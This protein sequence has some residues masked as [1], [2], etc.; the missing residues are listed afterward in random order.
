MWDVYY[1]GMRYNDFPFMFGF[2]RGIQALDIDDPYTIAEASH[3]KSSSDIGSI[4][5]DTNANQW[6]LTGIISSSELSFVAYNHSE[7]MP[8]TGILTHVSGASQTT[9]INVTD[10]TEKN[11][12]VNYPILSIDAYR[13]DNETEFS[14]NAISN[15]WITSRGLYEKI[16]K[17][18]NH[19][20][21]E[22][23]RKV[24]KYLAVPN[25]VFFDID[26]TK[27]YRVSDNIFL[28]NKLEMDLTEKDFDEKIVKAELFTV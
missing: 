15:K 28:I 21:T 26:M 7:S 25:R 12:T 3:D 23:K 24:I 8:P 1:S 5:Q 2:Y 4:W 13:Y 19:W 14:S 18:I 6:E 16:H 11:G 20:E 10:T 9:D 17:I 22:R 27:K